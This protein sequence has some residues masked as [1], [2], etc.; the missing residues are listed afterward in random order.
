M[1]WIVQDAPGS[2]PEAI[3]DEHAGKWLIFQEPDSCRRCMEKG[4]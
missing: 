4:S 3:E 2:A 1:Y